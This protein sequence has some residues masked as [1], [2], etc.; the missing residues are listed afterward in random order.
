M[1]ETLNVTP[2]KAV[3][4]YQITAYNAYAASFVA[5]L[6]DTLTITGFVDADDYEEGAVLVLW[7]HDTA[8]VPTTVAITTVVNTGGSLEVGI[9]RVLSYAGGGTAVPQ[10]RAFRFAVAD[11]PSGVVCDETTGVV[12]G[13]VA[14]STAVGGVECNALVATSEALVSSTPVTLSVTAAPAKAA[15]SWTAAGIESWI[16]AMVNGREPRLRS[17]FRVGT[18]GDA[19]RPALVPDGLRLESDGTVTSTYRTRY[20]VPVLSCFE[21]WM[22]AVGV[23]VCVDDFWSPPQFRRRIA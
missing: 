8:Q 3:Q 7:P 17:A 12:S 15:Y 19:G 6:S 18:A 13:S 10:A 1:F 22:M 21:P 20:A 5:S 2:G 14:F 11:A 23:Y 4:P 16:E 9:D